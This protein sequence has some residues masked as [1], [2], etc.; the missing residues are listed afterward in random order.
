MWN[1]SY[2]KSYP[3]LP[4]ERLSPGYK[5]E[6]QFPLGI[7]I[8]KHK[9]QDYLKPFNYE[10]LPKQYICRYSLFKMECN[11]VSKIASLRIIIIYF[12][13][14]PYILRNIILLTFFCCWK[15]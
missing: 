11:I 14:Y 15:V 1:G 10:G 5:E 8:L 4:V 2:L 9:I 12:L 6:R 7:Y 3:T 13:L